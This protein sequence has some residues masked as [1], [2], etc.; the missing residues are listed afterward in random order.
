M[1]FDRFFFFISAT[2]PSKPAAD[3]IFYY[4]MV[5]C[6]FVCFHLFYFFGP[7]FNKHAVKLAR[8]CSYL[9]YFV[10]WPIESGCINL[11]SLLEGENTELATKGLCF[12]PFHG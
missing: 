9:D 11:A 3:A 10:N 12:L 6:L 2:L 7:I 1:N 4:F 5:Y 8:N